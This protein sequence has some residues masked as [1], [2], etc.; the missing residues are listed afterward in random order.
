M[1][2]DLSHGL[3]E[4]SRPILKNKRDSAMKIAVSSK[5][6]DMEAALE[7]RFGRCSFFLII[8]PDDMNFDVVANDSA[9]LSGGAGI[10][11]AR[12]LVTKNV[13]AVITGNCGRKV[14]GLLSA[15]GID[16]YLGQ[17]GSI[18]E[19]L[20]R[21]RH[22]KLRPASDTNAETCYGLGQ[23][24]TWRLFKAGGRFMM[25]GHG[26]GRHRNQSSEIKTAKHSTTYN[27]DEL[28][29]LKRKVDRLNKEVK[30]IMDR[31]NRTD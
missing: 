18:K 14:V 28:K 10:R 22:G 11:S 9:T 3:G 19:V 24:R 1:R 17:T 12:F 29:G 13:N 26:E 20:E 23:R 4:R 5:G 25:T 21:F 2:E 15:A 31:M 7:P 30:E 6:Q 8:D 16:V 27:R